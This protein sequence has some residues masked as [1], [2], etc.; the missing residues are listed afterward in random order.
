VISEEVGHEVKLFSKVTLDWNESFVA[1][2]NRSYTTLFSYQQRQENKAK[3]ACLENE[4]QFRFCSQ[5][6]LY[7]P[8]CAFPATAPKMFV[9]AYQRHLA[10]TPADAKFG[11]AVFHEPRINPQAHGIPL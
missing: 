2:R 10:M 11:V 1:S 5:L 4:Y 8:L 3:F 7:I 9:G 6:Y